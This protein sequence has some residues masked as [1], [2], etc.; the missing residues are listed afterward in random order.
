VEASDS[1]LQ[2]IQQWRATITL[3][4]IADRVNESGE[5]T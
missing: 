3:Q 5:T 2:S 1:L 4:A